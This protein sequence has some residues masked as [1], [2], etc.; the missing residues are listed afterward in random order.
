MSERGVIK[1]VSNTI[2]RALVAGAREKEVCGLE[3]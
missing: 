2:G 3:D 1:R